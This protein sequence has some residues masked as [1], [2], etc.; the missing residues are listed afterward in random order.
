MERANTSETTQGLGAGIAVLRFDHV[1]E[2]V[3]LEAFE[4]IV[5][6]F[7]AF[8]QWVFATKHHL[9]AFQ[10]KS[11]SFLRTVQP[12]GEKELEASPRQNLQG[13]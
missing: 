4:N 2:Q 1:S 8:F 11:E 5:K 13:R 7:C 3:P 9:G 10:V 6:P 12:S